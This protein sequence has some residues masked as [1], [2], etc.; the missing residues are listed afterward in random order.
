[1]LIGNPVRAE[2]WITDRRRRLPRT[3]GQIVDA[4]T[5]E[6]LAVAEAVY[7]PAPEERKRELKARYQFRLVDDDDP[8]DGAH[9]SQ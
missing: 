9:P 2:G 8:S 3:Q 6:V 4:A 1:V 5:G 7:V